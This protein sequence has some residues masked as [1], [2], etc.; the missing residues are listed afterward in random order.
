MKIQSHTLSG[1]AALALWSATADAAPAR[2]LHRMLHL[3]QTTADPNA[4]ASP[5]GGA[6][7]GS[8]PGASPGALGAPAAPGSGEPA[9]AAPTAAAPPSLPPAIPGGTSRNN[10]AALPSLARPDAGG[11]GSGSPT[12]SY[13]GPQTAAPPIYG[14]TTRDPGSVTGNLS[15]TG[16][17]LPIGGPINGTGNAYD[18]ASASVGGAGGFG[19][20]RDGAGRTGTGNTLPPLGS[21]ATTNLQPLGGRP[22]TRDQLGT[23]GGIGGY[24]QQ[25]VY[26]GT[27]V[28][29]GSNGYGPASTYATVGRPTGGLLSTNV[30]ATGPLRPYIP[31]NAGPIGR[32]NSGY[33]IPNGSR[34]SHIDGRGIQR[35]D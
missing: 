4:P 10:A 6:T 35:M 12:V 1:L 19:A 3:A 5:D 24:S 22:I 2:P 29:P 33:G 8:D 28:Q 9:P 23:T 26:N 18:N 31:L 34:P 13:G 25:G 16:V 20:S 11:L 21:T 32:P 30:D 27:A 14:S 7:P 15:A 17:P